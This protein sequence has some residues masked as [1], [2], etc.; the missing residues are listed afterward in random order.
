M[1]YFV[2]CEVASL[3]RQVAMERLL[4]ECAARW[5][6]SAHER[7]RLAKAAQVANDDSIAADCEDI[8]RALAWLL[9]DSHAIRAWLHRPHPG[10]YHATPL[11][12]ILGSAPG[13]AQLRAQLLEEAAGSGDPAAAFAAGGE[14]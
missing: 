11:A 14:P 9:T 3:P 4:D 8:D 5:Q 7:L 12:I 6:L 2:F 13:R 10:L 1:Y